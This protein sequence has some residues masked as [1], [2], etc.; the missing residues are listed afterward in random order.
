MN[1][2]IKLVPCEVYTRVVGYYRPLSQ[3]NKGKKA[4]HAERKMIYL[5]KINLGKK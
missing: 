1:N 2:E 4:E 3:F 5:N